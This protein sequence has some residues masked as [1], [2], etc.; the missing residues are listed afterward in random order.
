M[1]K[2]PTG[3]VCEL[4]KTVIDVSG[5]DGWYGVGGIWAPGEKYISLCNT[6]DRDCFTRWSVHGVRPS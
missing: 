1:T 4:C 3:P 6:K 5:K 2:P